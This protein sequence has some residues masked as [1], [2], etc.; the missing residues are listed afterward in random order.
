MEE[1][2]QISAILIYSLMTPLGKS[3][4][5]HIWWPPNSVRKSKILYK[6]EPERR[7]QHKMTKMDLNM[8]LW[9]NYAGSPTVAILTPQ[10]SDSHYSV[11][12]LL[13]QENARGMSLNGNISQV[14][15]RSIS[16]FIRR[17]RNVKYEPAKSLALRPQNILS[18][19]EGAVMKC[20][21]SA[22]CSHRPGRRKHSGSSHPQSQVKLPGRKIW[23]K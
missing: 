19:S 15:A 8:S 12:L 5:S 11:M 2:G 3:I 21:H 6:I 23:K 17:Q 13:K 10:T 16:V 22:H 7:H 9:W 20:C 18:G 1:R 4:V 14:S